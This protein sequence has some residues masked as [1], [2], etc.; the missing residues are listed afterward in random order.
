[1]ED[2]SFF[3][4]ASHYPAYSCQIFAVF[5]ENTGDSGIRVT[6]CA[7]AAGKRTSDNYNHIK[8]LIQIIKYVQIIIIMEYGKLF[9]FCAEKSLFQENH[10][11]STILF[12]SDKWKTIEKVIVID[13]CT[14]IICNVIKENSS[15]SCLFSEDCPL[16]TDKV[17]G[18]NG[19]RLVRKVSE[20]NNSWYFY[21]FM[22]CIYAEAILVLTVQY[23]TARVQ[24]KT[25]GDEM[26]VSVLGSVYMIGKTAVKFS[27]QT[28]C[29]S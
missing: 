13:A 3:H 25:C 12:K 5:E 22:Q 20:V 6:K 16:S 28:E 17:K 21:G 7:A 29:I 26:T 8:P 10:I 24:P 14:K 9:N 4:I 19:V 11:L 15:D 23:S 1:M 27:P 2:R 18:I